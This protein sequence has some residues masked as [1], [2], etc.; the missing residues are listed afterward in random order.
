MY[1]QGRT[2]TTGEDETRIVQDAEE[3]RLSEAEGFRTTPTFHPPGYPQN[4]VEIDASRGTV[5]AAW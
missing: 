3:Q 4:W 5:T 1:R 2:K